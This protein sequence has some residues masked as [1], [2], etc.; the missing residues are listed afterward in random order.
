MC[1]QDGRDIAGLPID[2]I[3][4]TI[5]PNDEQRAALDDLANAS[6]KAAQ[7]LRAACPTDVALTAPKRLEVMQ[8]R[9]EAMSAAVNTVQSP[10]EKFYGL[11]DDEQKARLTA[12]GQQ[13]VRRSRRS[14][15][16]ETNCGDSQPGFTAWPTAEIDKTV[17]P[18]EA[19]RD[20]LATL[21]NAAAKAGDMLKDS[22][23]PATALTPPARLTAVS[24]RLDTM[25]Q[26]VKTV[27][28]ALDPFYASLS[29]EQKAAFDAITPQRAG[30]ADAQDTPQGRDRHRRHVV[31]VERMIRSLISMIR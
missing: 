25:L 16:V 7:D 30:S 6:V 20:G 5:R 29:D 4:R 2:A 9:I 28:S 12:L 3:Q 31:N 13:T 19:Q 15:P 22:C 23:A 14:A 24:K 27:R 1:G 26:A 18:T 8:S 11:L 10:L 21:Q 17:K